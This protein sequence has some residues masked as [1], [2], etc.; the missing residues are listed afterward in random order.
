MPLVLFT[1]ITATRCED[2]G[3][4]RK[5][6]ASAKTAASAIPDEAAGRADEQKV[7]S[8]YPPATLY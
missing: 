8:P 1:P 4:K 6:A 7:E 3:K 5:A 2:G